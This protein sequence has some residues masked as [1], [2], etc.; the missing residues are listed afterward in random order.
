MSHTE[1]RRFRSN[2]LT[3][4]VPGA[5]SCALTGG[6][7]TN[8]LR[9]R[10]LKVRLRVVEFG[11]ADLPVLPAS[12]GVDFDVV[13]EE[14]LGR[15]V[16]SFIMGEFVLFG[17]NSGAKNSVDRN[18][19]AQAEAT[20]RVEV[21]PLTGVAHIGR[22]RHGDGYAVVAETIDEHGAV[23]ATR[24]LICEHLFLAA[25]SLGTTKLLLDARRRRTLHGLGDDVGQ[26]WGHNG[27]ELAL[28]VGVGPTGLVSGGPSPWIVPFDDNPVGP[29]SIDVASGGLGEECLASRFWAWAFPGHA[30]SCH[31]TW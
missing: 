19:L 17:A 8:L 9:G 16:P 12:A 21:R 10:A 4:V 2:L 14:L 26:R 22:A 29:S 3:K 7:A 24:T 30:E 20:G 5:N 18:Y 15:V 31:W 1:G 28:R 25:G 27:D 23:V 11:R 13:R 6:K